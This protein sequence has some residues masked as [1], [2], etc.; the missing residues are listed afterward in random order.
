M[1]AKSAGLN[2]RWAPTAMMV[3]TSPDISYMC[4]RDVGKQT[5]MVGDQWQKEF[6]LL[7]FRVK[8]W[9]P[10]FATQKGGSHANKVSMSSIEKTPAASA[11]ARVQY[12]LFNAYWLVEPQ[13]LADIICS[14]WLH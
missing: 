7:T 13:L 9:K 14:D 4:V 5:G 8:D 2:S 1:T 11:G 6:C 3:S 12:C 10:R